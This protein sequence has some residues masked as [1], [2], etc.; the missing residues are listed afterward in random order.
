MSAPQYSLGLL[1]IILLAAQRHILPAGG[2]QN[3]AG[4]GDWAICSST[5]SCPA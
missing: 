3:L 1:F 2:M 4:A 5:C